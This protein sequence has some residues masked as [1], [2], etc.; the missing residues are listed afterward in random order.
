[1][2]ITVEL[3]QA[4]VEVIS[5]A[6]FTLRYHLQ[7]SKIDDISRRYLDAIQDIITQVAI[8]QGLTVNEVE[9]FSDMSQLNYILDSMG[10]FGS[11]IGFEPD[12]E[13]DTSS[14]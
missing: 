14:Q 4:G 9:A 8:Q 13:N 11:G 3:N 1:M 12:D 6:L 5:Q 7:G 10:F 2:K